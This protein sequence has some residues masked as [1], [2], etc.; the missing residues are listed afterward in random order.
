MKTKLL[1][2]LIILCTL[3]LTGQTQK[4]LAD[5]YLDY[6]GELVFTFVANNIEEARELSRIITFDHGLDPSN[7]LV[8]RAIANKKNFPKFLKYNLEYQV[9]VPANEPKNVV[10]FDPKIHKKGVS[11][12]SAAY[13]LTFPLVAYPT[14]Q[15][16]S[17][18]MNAFATDHSDIAQLI[19]IGGTVQG[20]AGGDK[21][22]LFIKLSDNVNTREAEPRVMYTSSMHG[23]ELAGFPS[24]LNLIDYFITAYKDTGH[25]DHTRIKNLLDN[26]EVWINPMA[27]PDAT[28]W[29]DN[30]N[31]SVANS[32]RENAN[33]IDLNRNYPDNVGGAFPEGDPYQTETLAFMDFAA[34][35]H[36]VLSANLHGGVELVNYPFDNA[37]ATSAFPS[38]HPE[39]TFNSGPFYTHPD[40]NWFEYVCVEYA[41]QAQNDSPNGYMTIDKDSYIYPS[42]GVT[43]GAEWYR[44]YGGRQ[45]YMNFYHQCREITLE[46]SD[47]YTPPSTDTSSENEVIDIWYYNQEAFIKFLLQG[48]YGF[49][50]IVKDASTGIPIDAK[51]SIVGR[52][53]KAT[54]ITNSWVRT[55]IQ[56]GDGTG[57]AIGDFYRPIEAGTYDIIVEADCY[58]P[59]TF[60]NKTISNYETI[61]LG[62]DIATAEIEPILLTPLVA[63][64]PINL[65]ATSI[66]ATTATLNWDDASVT[67]YDIQY[68]VDGTSTWTSA[69]S[70]TNSLGVTGL[71]VNTTYEFQVRGVC[72]SNPSAWSA[73]QNFTTTSITYCNSSGDT[74]ARGIT[75]VTFTGET[76]INNSDAT[77]TNSGY[78]D[79]TNISADVKLNSSYNISVGVN[80]GGNV[81]MQIIVWIDFNGN[82]NFYDSGEAFDLGQ[83]RNVNGTAVNISVPIPAN[84]VTGVTRMRI[85]AKQSNG[86]DPTSCETGFSGEVEDYSLNIID[87]TLAVINEELNQFTMY[88]NPSTDSELNVIL[89]NSV[90]DFDISIFS[91]LG[92]QVY[93]ERINTMDTVHTIN[94]GRLN[95]GVYFV[96]IQ[97]ELGKATK[98][99]IIQ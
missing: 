82:G 75:N 99:L 83:L 61:V 34:D 7:P 40:T 38:Q 54:P 65:S 15:Q 8:I 67:S 5:K 80:S 93:A 70:I 37:Y 30:T 46:L 55:E 64:A 48:T 19:D 77:N 26:S 69:T 72:N 39:D 78:E 29:N 98:K 90:K 87:G 60:S 91:V 25:S 53:D 31:T 97:T 66:A 2:V 57:D 84:A 79:F 32:R 28:Y 41:S 17:D 88:P 56:Y 45:D 89:P 4:E 73:S 33:N 6:R 14:Y 47:T 95:S 44:V 20:V 12:K 59:I 1:L 3:N 11:G 9:D 43:H 18:Q 68:R 76:S 13:P 96:T 94:I 23:D 36:F 24:M 42:P 10:M 21:R 86:T 22:L 81:R 16:Y 63:D 74:S 50:G 27:N 92:K 35:Y 58:E 85:S 49:R 62:D 52:D 51:I 71:S